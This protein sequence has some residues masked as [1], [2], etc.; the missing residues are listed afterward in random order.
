MSE[1]SKN[2][3]EKRQKSTGCQALF[4]RKDLDLDGDAESACIRYKT[5]AAAI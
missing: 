3:S 4:F 2:E 5:H 1:K